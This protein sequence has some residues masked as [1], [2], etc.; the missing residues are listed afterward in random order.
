MSHA[1]PNNPL[2]HIN[3]P[4]LL[5]AIADCESESNDLAIG[6]R[7]ERGRYQIRYATWE[8]YS[9]QPHKVFAHVEPVARVVAIKYLTHLGFIL[10]DHNIHPTAQN[11]AQMWNAGTLIGGFNNFSE[12]VNNLYLD[13]L[14]PKPTISAP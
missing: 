2:L 12:R 11:L 14:S 5:K 13:A 4:I 1:V 8:M 6:R 9:H 10:L 7:G 3:V